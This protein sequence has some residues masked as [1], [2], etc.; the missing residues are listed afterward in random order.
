MVICG[1]GTGGTA[2]GVGR[3][4][5]EKIPDCQVCYA[6]TC[7]YVQNMHITIIFSF[8]IRL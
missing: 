4:M 8:L 5:K 1:T 2:A 6:I 7:T 3:K